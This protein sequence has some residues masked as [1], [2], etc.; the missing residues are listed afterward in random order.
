MKKNETLSHLTGLGIF[1]VVVGHSKGVLPEKATEIAL[2][3]HLYYFFLK[4]I[5]TIYLFHMPLFFFISGFLYFF[6][7]SHIKEG[8]SSLLSKKTKR[9][10]L[11]YIAV[12]SIAYPVK[13][14]MSSFALRP[15]NFSLLDFLYSV[16]YPWN[17]TIIFF[18]FLPTLFLMFPLAKLIYSYNEKRVDFSALFLFTLIHFLT[19]HE[20]YEG[21]FALLNLGGV[22]HN[23]I[24]FLLG[25]LICKY[26][27]ELI[28]EKNYIALFSLCFLVLVAIKQFIPQLSADTLVFSITGIFFSCLIVY[29][30]P[31]NSFRTLSTYSF[32]I[33]LLSWFPQV[34]V[35]VIFGQVFYFNIWISVL[36][37]ILLGI[38]V[39]II[40]AKVIKRLN[41]NALNRVLGM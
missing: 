16:F 26:R 17:N 34:A 9:L 11:P 39:P 27:S 25:G 12:S 37:S 32:Q 19:Q 24:Y 40:C 23:F 38:I 33:Y 20:N 41:N 18:W 35:R 5:E 21:V 22:L 29:V 28:T 8:Y 1:L 31:D 6:T 14:L 30:L 13:V 3:N 2:E 10:L 4:I 7:G 36:L 15:M